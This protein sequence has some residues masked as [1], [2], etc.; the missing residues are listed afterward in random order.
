[1]LI[2][3]QGLHLVK[4]CVK[5]KQGRMADTV[6][7]TSQGMAVYSGMSDTTPRYMSTDRA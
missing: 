2:R 5:L 4:F 7:V 1:M 6:H 3:L